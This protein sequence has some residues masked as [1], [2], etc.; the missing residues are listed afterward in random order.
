MLFIINT[1]ATTVIMLNLM[2]S[3]ISNSFDKINSQG[4][5]AS[6]REKA[7]LI[8]ENQFLLSA[9]VKQNWCLKNKYLLFAQVLGNQEEMYTPEQQ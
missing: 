6:Y 8:A 4:T 3:I 2:I 9:E 7:G 5:Q 1:L